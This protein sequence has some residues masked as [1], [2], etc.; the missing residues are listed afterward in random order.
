MRQ[1]VLVRH[2]K[3]E[4]GFH[5]ADIDR[6]LAERGLRNA[7]EMARRLADRLEHLDAI[8]SS[9]AQRTQQTAHFFAQA[10][11]IAEADIVLRPGMYTFSGGG[12]LQELRHLDDAAHCVAVFGHNMAISEVAAALANRDL[13]YLPTCAVVQIA[14]HAETC[15]P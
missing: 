10:F 7:A 6:P 1:L 3:S 5:L 13:D 14:V 15:R 9:V 11:D 12:L 2:A 4:H 8:Y